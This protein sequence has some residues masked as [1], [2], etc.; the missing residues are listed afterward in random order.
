MT[1]LATNPGSTPSSVSQT[2][3]TTGKSPPELAQLAQLIKAEH[4]AVLRAPKAATT[5]KITAIR[6]ANAVGRAIKAGELLKEA[7]SKVEH[8]K[9]LPWLQNEC[10]IS[11]VRTAQRYMKWADD[12]PKLEKICR[13]KNVTM[14]HLT[15]GQ[16]ARLL[17]G[18]P[19]PSDEYDRAETALIRKLQKLP[20][21]EADAASKATIKKL[22]EA[23]ATEPVSCLTS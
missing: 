5:A 7:K 18:P 13:E 14:S 8:G 23:L 3:A 6:E 16:A 21:E 1:D 4:A 9:W 11:S 17:R 10:D 12:K 2:A 15:L 22:R 20:H 19:S